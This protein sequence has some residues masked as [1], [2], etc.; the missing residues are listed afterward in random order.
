MPITLGLA[1]FTLGA[2]VAVVNAAIGIASL[3]FLGVSVFQIGLSVGLS[4][5]AQ[6]LIPKPQQPKP[7]DVQQSSRQPTQPRIKHYG[8][9]KV[10]GAW[11]FAEAYQGDFH[12]VIALGVGPIDAI[13]E[14]WIDD[15]IVTLN[16][17]GVVQTSPWTNK[18]KI[19]KR[20]GLASETHYSSLTSVFSEWTSDHTGDYVASLYA[21]QYAVGNEDYLSTF[22]N[23][24]Q[25]NYR[26]VI[27]GAKLTPIGGGTAAWGDNAAEVVYDYMLSS[28][29][30]RLPAA[31]LNTTEALAGW[32]AA[33][34]LADASVALKSGGTV[35]QYKSW[36]SYSLDE[37][38]ADVLSRMLASCDGRLKPTSDGGLTLDIGDW[39]EPTVTLDADTII[40]FSDLSRG[41]DILSTANIIRATYLDPNSDY[42]AA[43]AEPWVD[44]VDVAARGE[45]A[46]DTSYIMAPNH[47]QARRLMK[48]AYYRSNP[49]WV[50]TFECNLRALAAIDQRFVRITYPLF[51]IDEVFEVQEVRFNID[52][53]TLRS[54]TIT[55][56][57]MPE[58][59]YNWVAADEEGTAPVTSD[60]D[61]S[62]AIPNPTGFTATVVRQTIGGTVLPY[63]QVDMDNPPS[64]ALLAGYRYK[65]TAGSTWTE[66]APPA[67][68]TLSEVGPLQDGVEYEFQARH[69]TLGG[70]L[71][72]WTSSIDITPTADETAP[73]VVTLNSATGGS[74]KVDFDWTTP[75]SANFSRTVIR[76][77]TV[78]NEGGAI[79][80]TN[81]PIFGAANTTYT[82][83]DTSLTAGTYYYW[84]Y[85]ANVSAVESAAVAT[86]AIVVT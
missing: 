86:G 63:V 9:A 3:S 12:K 26:V 42:Q 74:A 31:V 46:L 41:R 66:F 35:A 57:S 14:Y 68:D 61:P 15:S 80:I 49:N 60:T 79:E 58:E 36:G 24:I 54:V 17:S 2:P 43:D 37:R 1:L 76:R 45:I 84:I 69:T 75:N 50:G 13:E 22:P 23:G 56:Q 51:S 8:R 16:G 70:R 18:C 65:T 25:T 78:D 28:D 19:E 29:G 77:N 10:S 21:R 83:S 4:F 38:P 81:S 33:A 85:A 30:M 64:A 47:S 6:A 34:T 7:E 40:G 59:A 44:D 5:L 82:V 72:S 71:G 27:R 52:G 53:D 55:A 67:G 39:E 48:R 32:N 73:G 62:G 20:L 11:A